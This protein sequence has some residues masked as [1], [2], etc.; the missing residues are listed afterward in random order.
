MAHYQTSHLS[1][2]TAVH[3]QPAPSL[4][5]MSLIHG[6]TT[7]FWVAAP[8]FGIGALICGALFR[9]GP[10]PDPE[11]A[12][13]APAGAAAQPAAIAHAAAWRHT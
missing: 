8:I 11:S 2:A 13:A 9:F 3:G 10:L 12:I 4:I 6:Y 5:G 1:P 7:G